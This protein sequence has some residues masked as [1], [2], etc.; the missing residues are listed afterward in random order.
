VQFEPGRDGSV[1]GV[2]AGVDRG[3]KRV[4]AVAVEVAGDRRPVGLPPGVMIEQRHLEGGH[5]CHEPQGD[6]EEQDPAAKRDRRERSYRCVGQQGDPLLC[7][8][9]S[10]QSSHRDCGRSDGSLP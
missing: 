6:R 2:A 3:P 9:A 5:P 8:H 4:E 7:R 10:P 1:G